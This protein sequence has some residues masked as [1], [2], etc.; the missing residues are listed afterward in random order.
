M[1]GQRSAGARIGV[2]MSI[3]FVD[4]AMGQQTGDHVHDRIDITLGWLDTVAIVIVIAIVGGCND[5][6]P[7]GGSESVTI[8]VQHHEVAGAG[9][10]QFGSG[11]SYFSH[12]ITSFSGRKKSQAG[13]RQY[14]DGVR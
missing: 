9:I 11:G 7:V 4:H 8:V 6:G 5:R 3:H 1:L 12:Y 2:V 13:V 14:P 10:V